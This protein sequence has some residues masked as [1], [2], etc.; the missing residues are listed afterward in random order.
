M[1]PQ[2]PHRENGLVRRPNRLSAPYR[3]KGY[4]MP[5]RWNTFAEHDDATVI[6]ALHHVQI[7]T[8]ASL[9]RLVPA[10]STP[11]LLESRFHP[12]KLPQLELVERDS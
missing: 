3:G 9:L 2:S 7:A 4:A 10:G 6:S 5:A 1:T 12:W 8:A 11:V